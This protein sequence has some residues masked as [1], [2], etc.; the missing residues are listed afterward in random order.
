MFSKL[1]SSCD[2][3]GSEKKVAT[4]VTL[5][6]CMSMCAAMKACTAIDFGKGNRAG[7]C[8]VNTGA[9]KK[10]S[11]NGGFDAYVKK[12]KPVPTTKKPAKTTKPTKKPTKPGFVARAF[13]ISCPRRRILRH[14]PIHDSVT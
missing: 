8:F 2:Y 10:H 13:L 9:V 14:T 6:K 5:Q 3:S 4:G 12:T 11:P 1:C 7:E